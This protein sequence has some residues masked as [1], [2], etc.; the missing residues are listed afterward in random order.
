M[1]VPV[2]EQ[3]QTQVVPTVRVRTDVPDIGG[4]EARAKASAARSISDGLNVFAA[5]LAALSEQRDKAAAAA[6]VNSFMTW[7]NDYL[8]NPQTGILTRKGLSVTGISEM[9]D[10][11]YRD[12]IEEMSRELKTDYQRRLFSDAVAGTV[13]S[14]MANIMTHEFNGTTAAKREQLS[15]GLAIAGDAIAQDFLNDETFNTQQD[16][17]DAAVREL[18]GDWGEE[19]VRAKLAESLSQAHA[20]RLNKMIQHDPRLARQYFEQ[21]KKEIQSAQQDRFESAIKSQE[22]LLWTQENADAYAR[23][24]ADEKSAVADIRRRYQGEQEERLVS[25]VKMRFNERQIRANS[26]EAALHRQQRI[27]YEQLYDD[28][29]LNGNFPSPEKLMQMRRDGQLSIAQFQSLQ[30]ATASLSSRAKAEQFVRA[31]RDYENLTYQEREQYVRERLGITDEERKSRIAA[32]DTSLWNGSLSAAELNDAYTRGFISKEEM[33][34]YKKD[35]SGIAQV[36][37]TFVSNELKA[38]RGRIKALAGYDKPYMTD[39]F[40]ALASEKLH[41]LKPESPEYRKQAREAI[42]EACIE[43][44]ESNNFAKKT[45]F[46]FVLTQA[47]ELVQQLEKNAYTGSPFGEKSRYSASQETKP[48]TGGAQEDLDTILRGG[49]P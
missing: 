15:A 14:S 8:R 22:L 32:L 27:N 37:K 36:Q 1:R 47:G 24:F 11:A 46:G 38:A 7:N 49:T 21:N 4:I 35:I 39:E 44:I 48:K 20:L 5:G 23:R 18:W 19:V 28:M 10:S 3:T 2:Y 9:S 30:N 33:E 26:A 6:A 34:Y 25:A 29:T 12:K 45:W 42:N 13:R 41:A 17:R 16:N 40:T 43:V 31:N